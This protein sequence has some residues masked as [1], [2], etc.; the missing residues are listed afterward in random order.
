MRSRN[1][2]TVIAT[3]L[4]EDTEETETY[5]PQMRGVSSESQIKL[6]YWRCVIVFFATSLVENPTAKHRLYS[7]AVPPCFDGLDVGTVLKAWK[8]ELVELP[9][10]FSLKQGVVTQWGNQF[11]ILD[12]LKYIAATCDEA[13][14]II[15]D[16]DCV[17]NGSIQPME[18]A[19]DRHGILTYDVYR[20]N[21]DRDREIN[22]V[23]E[24][25]LSRFI[26]DIYSLEKEVK[27]CGGEIFAASTSEIQNLVGDIDTLWEASLASSP[28][29][30]KEE[31]HFLSVLYAVNNIQIGTADKFIRRIWTSVRGSSARRADLDLAIW[32]LPAEKRLGFTS[33]FRILRI[34]L[35]R[36]E[37]L[38]APEI[39]HS[40]LRRH[41]GVPKRTKMKFFSDCVKLVLIRLRARS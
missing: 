12:I 26:Q 7:N 30:P 24:R 15:L 39:L 16:S 22:G 6:A 9:L 8:V 29:V 14:H 33:L 35:R 18:Q 13:R 21:R 37:K 11:Y 2:T 23:S 19:I 40:V 31:A 36:D 1:G 20:Q 32:H 4:F 38:G 10:S 34:K 17:W 5:F 41:L 27:Y 28:K 3:W 25:D